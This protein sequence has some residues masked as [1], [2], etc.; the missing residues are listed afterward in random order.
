MLLK[1]IRRMFIFLIIIIIFLLSCENPDKTEN[2]GDG[3]V[4]HEDQSE[5]Q[6]PED[7]IPD[8]YN[9]DLPDMDF[10]GEPFRIVH[11]PDYSNSHGFLMTAEETGDVI[12]DAIY[13]AN[14]NV[15]ERFNIVFEEA[16]KISGNNFGEAPGLLRKS[17][18][19]GEN[20]Y[21]YMLIADRDAFALA[22]EGKYFHTADE[23]IHVKLRNN[24]VSD[25]R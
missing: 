12:N 7:D 15:E 11:F 20:S 17:V 23:L 18:A 19:A 4:A 2:S 1:K 24:T 14:K 13:K 16:V 9:D 25:S 10:N 8:L 6:K 21:D 3:S 5:A 22:M